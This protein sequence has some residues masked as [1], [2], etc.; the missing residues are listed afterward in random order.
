MR[1][2]TSRQHD[3]HERGVGG[4][5]RGWAIAVWAAVL[6]LLVSAP[7]VHATATTNEARPELRVPRLQ[8]TVTLEDFAGM[9]PTG[10]IARELVKAAEFTQFTP[11]VGQPPTQRTEVYLGHDGEKLYVAFLAFDS[12][13]DRI[14][15]RMTRRDSFQADDDSVWLYIDAFNDQRSA[16][17]FG[18]NGLGVQYDGINVPGK[19]T[20]PSWDVPWASRG[21]LTSQGFTVLM[22]IPFKSLRFPSST[23]RGWGM[24]FER[25][26]PR[27]REDTFWPALPPKSQN[28]LVF[29]GLATGL[30]RISP[31]RNVQLIPYTSARS[32]RTSNA[33]PKAP[34]D[35]KAS[36]AAS[37]IG[38]D[39]KV[40][41]SDRWVL[42]TTIR[43]DF[44]QVE[45]DEPQ[46]SVNQRYEVYYP[47]K[48]PF[49]ME[50]A[51]YFE[52][53]TITNLL[54]TRRI[55]D[56]EYGVRLSG[57]SG[58][59]A[60]GALVADDRSPDHLA[61]PGDPLEGEK[62]RFE[63]VRLSR[64][65]AGQSN[66]GVF[67]T[68][69]DLAGG[70]NRV[71]A[72]DGRF[73]LAQ[74]WSLALLA[75]SSTTL[76]SDG[77]RSSGQAYEARL[78]RTSRSFNCDIAYLDRSPGY[79][80]QA[81]FLWKND[82]RDF[83]PTISYSFW[84]Q[85]GIV[86]RLTPTLD[87]ELVWDYEGTQVQNR[88][89]L[90]VVGELTKIRS[91]ELWYE[92]RDDMLR[93]KDV[94]LLP[95]VKRYPQKTGGF[96]LA[97]RPSA[98]FLWRVRLGQ[99]TWLNLVPPAGVQPNLAWYTHGEAALS[100]FPTGSLAIENSY[101]L[102]RLADRTSKRGVFTNHVLRSKWNWQISRELSLRL[103]LRYDAILTN[104]GLTSLPE[105]GN[106]NGDFLIT[107]L[108][109]PGTAVYLGY[110]SNY[111]RPDALDGSTPLQ[112]ASFLNDSWQVYA[113]VSYLLRL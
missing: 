59:W 30:E 71:A 17:A 62:A 93:P 56:P 44:S 105:K 33:S 65:L 108:L 110:N 84:P 77:E 111:S 106:L 63:V 25:W 104:P 36:N 29:A 41:V 10:E 6:F 38:L 81:G 53:P 1:F 67:L 94:A 37:D 39:G 99:G 61:Q 74:D 52:L 100:V 91:F 113:K 28:W 107:Y 14:R 2:S 20:D 18:C 79:D 69:R 16:Y 27:R 11:D 102:D 112:V 45:S 46:S 98:Y 12:E 88:V 32:F 9:R 26:L 50:N 83:W 3:R 66:L 89:K 58:S 103:I 109:H 51:S 47:E 23:E 80:T 60:V 76:K 15:A 42:D 90:S 75:A 4:K 70:Y 78:R 13:P 55:A 34:V 92:A 8:R 85:H 96:Q 73:K 101:L 24:I 57:K 95:E 48:R 22:A 82:I 68:E 5:T 97:G 72:A 87:A 19:D 7:L 31:G 86:T 21:V 43:P 64:D 35:A 40:V 54:F 49:F